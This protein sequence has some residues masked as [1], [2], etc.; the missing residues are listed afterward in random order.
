[1]HNAL[2]F[3]ARTHQKN[4][5]FVPRPL[6]DALANERHSTLFPAHGFQIK[7]Q[8]LRLFPLY[9]TH[10]RRYERY[11]LAAI[12]VITRQRAAAHI[13]STSRQTLPPLRRPSR[14]PWIIHTLLNETNSAICSQISVRI[15]LRFLRN[16]VTAACFAVCAISNHFASELPFGAESSI[17]PDTATTLMPEHNHALDLQYLYANSKARCHAG[18]SLFG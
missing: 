4:P 17:S 10:Q 8:F 6:I 16:A 1:M 12:T 2:Y 14:Q 18:A 11:K 7:S 15:T 9:R 13:K 5:H 3:H